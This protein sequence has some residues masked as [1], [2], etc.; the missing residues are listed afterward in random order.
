MACHFKKSG[1]AEPGLTQGS[2]DDIFVGLAVVTEHHLPKGCVLSNQ[3]QLCSSVI[4]GS[5]AQ[6]LEGL[7]P[8]VVI[9]NRHAACQ[10][11]AWRNTLGNDM[12]QCHASY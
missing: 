7:H 6:A 11:G 4:V 12:R 3:E 8:V 5:Q 1:L 2:Q 9:I 10:W